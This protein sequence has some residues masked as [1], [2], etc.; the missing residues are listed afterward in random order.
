MIRFAA[1]S[2]SVLALSS[3][4]HAQDVI[5]SEQADFIVET[6]AGGLEYPWSIAFL[7]DG[8]YLVTEREGRLRVIDENGLREAPVSGLPD[9]LLVERQGGLLDVALAPDFA[10]SRTIYF[11]YAEGTAEANN[12]A[13]ARAQLSSDL[14]TLE[15]VEDIFHVNFE[16]ARGFHFGGRILFNP[17]GTLFLTLGD[18][19]NYQDEAQNPENHLGAVVRL[20]L[21]G[22][23]PNDNPEI[24]NGAPGVYSFGHRNAQGIARNPATGSVWELEHG[25]RGGDEINILASGDNYGWPVITYGINYDGTIITEDRE[26]DG[27]TQPIWYWN[28]SIAPS[29]MDFYTGDAF[30]HWQGDL[31]VS[32]LAG[33]KVERLEIDGDRVISVEPLLADMGQRFRDV[34]TGPDGALYVLTD[35]FEGSVLRLVPAEAD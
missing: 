17:D 26:R 34:R 12:T 28:P 2:L 14:T 25:A 31:F 27:L 9:D 35:D 32:A 4:S 8:A 30:E 20:N 19:G 1:A 7:P 16:K 21:D 18:G 3:A 24:E 6:V 29:G 33:S 11:S 13:L 23:I 15:N 5:E 10:T 22:S